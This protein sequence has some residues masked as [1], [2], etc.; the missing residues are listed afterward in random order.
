MGRV[1]QLTIRFS[2]SQQRDDASG[3]LELEAHQQLQQGSG[4]QLHQGLG[5][6]SR[7]MTRVKCWIV[8][9]WCVLASCQSLGKH[10]KSVPS[11]S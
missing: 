9:G 7:G 8:A 6:S 2:S 4:V 1:A 5:F 10:S 3:P 11:H